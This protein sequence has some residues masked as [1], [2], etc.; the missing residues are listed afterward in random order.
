VL[1]Y[2]YSTSY[3]QRVDGTTVGTVLY[4]NVLYCTINRIHVLVALLSHKDQRSQTPDDDRHG[5]VLY[6]IVPYTEYTL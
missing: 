4:C 1:D 6:C 3:K 5:T 2:S